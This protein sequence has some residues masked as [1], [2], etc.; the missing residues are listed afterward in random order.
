M[1]APVCFAK[2]FAHARK[3]RANPAWK[4]TASAVSVGN[5]KFDKD[6]NVTSDSITRQIT[7]VAA[8]TKPTDAVNVAQLTGSSIHYYS[9]SDVKP[10]GGD[11]QTEGGSNYDNKGAV[12][13]GSLAAGFYAN[14]NGEEATAFGYNSQSTEKSGSS[15]GSMSKAIA[16]NATA[17]GHS[18][19]ARGTDATATGS[20]SLAKGS[21][22]VATGYSAQ[23]LASNSSAYGV[24][25]VAAGTNSSAMGL[26]AEA[27]GR[28]AIAIGH[29]TT[30]GALVKVIQE[31]GT[32]GTDAVYT[33]EV[34]TQQ[35]KEGNEYVFLNMAATD[36]QSTSGDQSS[37]GNQS[38]DATD[39]GQNVVSPNSVKPFAAGRKLL[40]DG[41]SLKADTKDDTAATD[42]ATKTIVV[43]YNAANDKYYAASS[44]GKGGYEIDFT[45]EIKPSE[46]SLNRGGIT[47]GSYAHAEGDRSLA[48]GRASGSYGKNSSA[49]GIYANAVGDGDLALGHGASTGV[50]AEIV[51][52]GKEGTAEWADGFWT[53]EIN[54]DT[55][56]NPIANTAT[57]G[58]AIGSYSHTEGTRALAVG[59]VASAYGMN[60]T[61]IGLRSSAYGEGSIAFGH[62]VVAGNEKEKDV[63][64]L[65][66]LHNNPKLENDQGLPYDLDGKDNIGV[67]PTKVVGAVAIGSYAEATGRGS[68]SVGRYSQAKSAYSTTLGIRANV[69]DSAEN[70]IAIGREAEVG[71]LTTGR[72]YGGLNSIAIGTM[73]KVNGQNSIAIGMADMLNEDGTEI[74]GVSDRKAT[75]VTGDKS[76][77]IGMHDTVVGNSSIAIGTGHQ[78]G[79]NNSGAI[80][81]PNVVNAD[82]SY[83]VGNNSTIEK[84][85][86]DSFIFGNKRIVNA[87]AGGSVVLGSA[88]E[89]TTTEAANS[90]VIGYDANVELADYESVAL[91]SG[92]KADRLGGYASPAANDITVGNLTFSSSAFAGTGNDVAGTVSV[93]SAGKTRTLT[94][95]GA[96]E[97]SATSTDAINGSQLYSAIEAMQ[98]DIVAGDNVEVVKD[99]QNG[100]TVYTIHS[101]NAIVEEGPSGNVTV[102]PK[103][104][105]GGKSN[106]QTTDLTGGTAGTGSEGTATPAT[107]GT[108]SPTATTEP[109]TPDKDNNHTTTYTVDA[110][111]NTITIYEIPYTTT[112]EAIIDE[113]CELVKQGKIKEISDIRNSTDL[114]G[115]KI[116]IECKRGNTLNGFVQLLFKLQPALDVFRNL[117]VECLER[118]RKEIWIRSSHKGVETREARQDV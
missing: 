89:D 115:L 68:L 65:A 117:A 23:A 25:S 48:L 101:L 51:P 35:D 54:K 16:V 34:I 100:K 2:F 108:T 24:D 84:G 74:V 8:G 32:S 27:F 63:T 13:A 118:R 30:S 29:E 76:I 92:A 77:A 46:E 62:G 6:G 43:A 110:K 70:A 64:Q 97:I 45:K 93:G 28:G 75:S 99:K 58:I 94:Y 11:G 19:E 49:I 69:L 66:E 36:D 90:V 103:T 26:K 61:A 42:E 17:V 81:D 47:I 44:D 91:G 18:A 21:N 5:V 59:R 112:M 79:G 20:G 10:A 15:L 3:I 33:T 107:G 40:G 83:T 104:G 50:A 106:G 37:S 7:G 114:K 96:G 14:A 86:D 41:I 109:I 55:N 116:V 1:A 60:S 111:K 56:G 31:K 52:S 102:E 88:T 39:S 12:G 4:S 98:F 87:A 38:G 67:D 73:T 80:G 71:A 95:V 105:E 57:G 85:A 22:S 72:Q 78:V 113:V 53:T 82:N 9:V